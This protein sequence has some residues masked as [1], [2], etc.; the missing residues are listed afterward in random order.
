MLEV[1]L[2][3]TPTPRY[4]ETNFNHGRVSKIFQNDKITYVGLRFRRFW[5]FHIISS[6][7]LCYGPEISGYFRNTGGLEIRMH[8]R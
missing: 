4:F 6:G 1:T 7:T 8:I 5:E 3:Y 2:D